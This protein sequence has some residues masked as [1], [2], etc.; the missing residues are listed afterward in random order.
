MLFKKSK[1]GWRLLRQSLAVFRKYKKLLLFPLIGRGFFFLII[2]AITGMVWA[3]RSGLIDY[4]RL[5]TADIGWMY[6]IVILALWFGNLVSAYCNAA[7]TVCLIQCDQNQPISLTQGFRTA[8]RRWLIIFEFIL[9]YFTVGF[10]VNLFRSQFSPTGRINQLLSGLSWGMAIFLMPTLIINEPAG[11]TKTLQ[12]SSQLMFDFASPN[13]QL[14]FSYMWFSLLTRFIGLLPLLI[15]A[16]FH[17]L[18]VHIVGMVVTFFLLLGIVV[19]FNA[20]FVSILQALY[21]YIAHRRT[22]P[23]FQTSD[24]ETAIS[25]KSA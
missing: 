14:N 23:S 9:A 16:E 18:A 13:P 22:L 6:L 21:Q 15:A 1:H 3:I 4:N 20:A 7:L 12:R 24:L 8:A 11:F 25:S 17:S 2:V 19:L 5:S 10:W